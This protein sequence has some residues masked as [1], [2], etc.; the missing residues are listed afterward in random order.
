MSDFIIVSAAT[1]RELSLTVK[2]KL[3]LGYSVYA[4]AE[5]KTKTDGSLYYCQTLVRM[6][7]LA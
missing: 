7:N 3:A 2:E 1:S 5:T 4:D 6:D